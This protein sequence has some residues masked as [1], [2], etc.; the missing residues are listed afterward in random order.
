MSEEELQAIETRVAR[1][2]QDR[3]TDPSVYHGYVAALVAEVRRQRAT[4]D[5]VK[6]TLDD[7]AK[8]EGEIHE[9]VIM[10]AIDDALEARS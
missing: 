7:L 8:I 9:T 4:I 2:A 1:L 5:R 10:D 3:R 6:A